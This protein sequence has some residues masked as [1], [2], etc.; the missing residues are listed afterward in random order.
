MHVCPKAPRI[1]VTEPSSGKCR[2]SLNDVGAVELVEVDLGV[3][4]RLL[5]NLSVLSCHA[6]FA[7]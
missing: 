3:F 7:E 6:I 2:F 1:W 5:T 4:V